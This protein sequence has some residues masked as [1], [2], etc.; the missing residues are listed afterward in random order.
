MKKQ[1]LLAAACLFALAGAAQTNLASDCA[2]KATS[3]TATLG[4]DGNTGTRWESAQS[5]P[6]NWQVDLGE[7]KDFNTINIVWEGAYASTFTIEAGNTVGTD[8]YLTDGKTIATVDGQTLS[9][10]PYSQSIAVGD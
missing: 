9:G 8:G 6:Q 4:N 2:S 1:L 10:F 3:G 5:D 7:A